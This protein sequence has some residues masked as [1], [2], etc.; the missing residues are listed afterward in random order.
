MKR[1]VAMRERDVQAIGT[2]RGAR[3]GWRTVFGIVAV[4]MMAQVSSAPAVV[5]V[6]PDMTVTRDSGTVT[7]GKAV[8][9]DPTLQ[10]V[11]AAFVQNVPWRSRTCPR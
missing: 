5:H 10:E 7:G 11:L 2:R 1:E 3:V 9:A 4:A 6:L 8:R